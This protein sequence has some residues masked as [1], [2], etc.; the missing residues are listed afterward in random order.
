[1]SIANQIK[2]LTEDIEASY[3]TRITAV[4]DIVKETQQTLGNFSREHRKMA[5]DLIYFF[6]ASE[7]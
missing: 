3:G 1:M 7:K 5:D 6:S 2:S 4:S